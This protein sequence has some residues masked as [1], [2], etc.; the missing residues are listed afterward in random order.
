MNQQYHLTQTV[1]QLQQYTGQG[2]E[3]ISVYIPPEKRLQDVQ[4]RLKQEY[5]DAENIQSDTTQKHVQAALQ[6]LQ[7]LLD[8]LDETPETGVALFAG[9]VDGALIDAMVSEFPTPIQSSRY[10]C[11]A[12]FDVEPLEAVIEPETKYGL[13]VVERGRAAIGEVTGRTVREINTFE[14]HVM[15]KSRAGGQSA[16]RFERVRAKQVEDFF[17]SIADRARTAFLNDDDVTIDG[18]LIGGTMGAAEQ[19][20]NSQLLD[21]RLQDSL[22]GDPIKIEYATQI[23]L[24][25]LAAKGSD[26]I[27]TANLAE[28][29]DVCDQFFTA[30]RDSTPVAYGGFADDILSRAIEQGAVKTLL[31]T[32]ET[33]KTTESERLETVEQYGGE[34]VVIPTTTEAGSQLESG[35][36]GV[37]GILHYKIK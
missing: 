19:F 30:L 13:I 22:L 34:V 23:G 11:D 35:F 18:L 33:A 3:L 16:P 7:S 21:Y 1:E 36:G 26:R 17:N 8:G 14:S 10:R 37:G 6:R 20:T 31:V 28:V 5:A 32:D 4:N 2:T 27:E 24:E 9:Y 25:E 15:G 29:R 12:Q